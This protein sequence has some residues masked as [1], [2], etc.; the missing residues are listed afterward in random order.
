MMMEPI[1]EQVRDMADW[2]RNC[3]KLYENV[4]VN[5]SIAVPASLLPE[6]PPGAMFVT[7]RT[8][9]QPSSYSFLSPDPLDQYP[10]RVG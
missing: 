3:T 4:Y 2:H 6:F 1:K 9:H 7:T 8:D 10:P 5:M